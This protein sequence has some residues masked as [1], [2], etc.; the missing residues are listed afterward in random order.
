MIGTGSVEKDAGSGTVILMGIRRDAPQRLIAFLS[1]NNFG[2]T[3]FCR[4]DMD[5]RNTYT[6]YHFL[7]CTM[8]S[9][10]ASSVVC[11]EFLCTTLKRKR[12]RMFDERR[13][14][15]NGIGMRFA[16]LKMKA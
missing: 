16:T 8:S 9:S 2:T 3:A 6:R 15:P 12:I 1:T 7:R 10:P 13:V 5:F 14:Q 4:L 11:F